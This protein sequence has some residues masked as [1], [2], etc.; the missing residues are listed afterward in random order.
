MIPDKLRTF[1]SDERGV[2][3]AIGVILMVAITVILAAVIG[4][5]V[6]GLGDQLNS[7][8][9]QVSIGVD[10][11]A[12]TTASDDFLL[13]LNHNNGPA[14]QTA[15]LQLTIR[16]GTNNAQ[17]AQF[18]A[19]SSPADVDGTDTL[20]QI[21]GDPPDNAFSAG[22]QLQLKENGTDTALQNGVQYRLVIRDTSSDTILVDSTFTLG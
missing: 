12:N 5:F 21:N 10:A 13:R 17:L 15:N 11:G 6:L 3:P 19:D 4:S 8:G 18:A 22:D 16:N 9:P 20:V 2:S 7:Q 1:G 14:L